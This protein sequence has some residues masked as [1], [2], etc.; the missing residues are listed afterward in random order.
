MAAP[1][2]EVPGKSTWR[3]KAGIFLL[4]MVGAAWLLVP[5]AA[6]AGA[7]AGTIATLTGM[8][9]IWNKAIILLMV[10]VMGKPGFQEL[11]AKVLDVFRFSPESHIGPV[12]Y[13]VGLVMFS[14]PLITAVLEPYIYAAWPALRPQMLGLQIIGDLMF[15]VSFLVLGGSFWEKIRALFIRT[16]RVVDAAE[17]VS[18][19]AR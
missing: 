1:D 18:T 19:T 13:N 17:D 8:I 16:A 6:W 2:L 11:K 3:F 9:F 4:C 12:R 7:S 14:M 15:L 10:A 5:V